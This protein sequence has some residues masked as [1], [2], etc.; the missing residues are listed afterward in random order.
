MTVTKS[1]VYIFRDAEETEKALEKMRRAIGEKHEAAQP[2]SAMAL[3]DDF[4]N[5]LYT[6]GTV[7]RWKRN[8]AR[9]QETQAKR[10]KKT[11]HRRITIQTMYEKERKDE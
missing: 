10:K 3:L 7:D 11:K 6:D 9:G 1:D 5:G 8:W 2:A 4:I